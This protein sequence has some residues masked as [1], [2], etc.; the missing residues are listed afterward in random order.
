MPICI[1]NW[2][3]DGTKWICSVRT[4]N[5]QVATCRIRC[6]LSSICSFSAHRTSI[7]SLASC[8]TTWSDNIIYLCLLNLFFLR[9]C[10]L[11]VSQHQRRWSTI[12]DH[13]IISSCIFGRCCWWIFHFG[14]RQNKV[15]P[16]TAKHRSWTT[17]Q[18]HIQRSSHQTHWSCYA[19]QRG[20]S[21][22]SEGTK[23]AFCGRIQ[24]ET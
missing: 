18:A 20:R 11:F 22:Y 7:M 12:V 3:Q 1:Q 23:S 10:C 15:A 5:L 9:L 19:T 21:M 8:I 24:S 2:V 16:S 17:R 6:F 14:E 4:K 13:I